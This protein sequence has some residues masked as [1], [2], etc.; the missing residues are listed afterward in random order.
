MKNGGNNKGGG[1][2]KDI[3]G[4]TEDELKTLKNK[5]GVNNDP[6]ST[7]KEVVAQHDV[8]RE[9]IRAIEEKALKKLNPD[10]NDPEKN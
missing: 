8:T 4:L 6:K 2:I 1:T 7:L 5:F 9:R 3:D 10:D